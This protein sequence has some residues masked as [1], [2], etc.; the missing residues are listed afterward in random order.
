MN[1]PAPAMESGRAPRVAAFGELLL[2]LT[3]QG[4]QILTQARDLIAAYTG[5]EANAAVSLVRL[6]LR[7]SV[8]SVVPANAVGDA[9]VDYIRQFGV[10]THH[11]V[12]GGERLGLLYVEPGVGQRPTNVIYDREHSG[13]Q[14]ADPRVFDWPAIL[15]GCHWL[16]FSGTAPSRGPNIVQAIREG[17]AEAKRRRIPVSCDVNYRSR[18]WDVECARAVLTKL[19]PGVDYVVCSLADARMLIGGPDDRPLRDIA[20]SVRER[21]HLKAVV[22]AKRSGESSSGGA[23]C[24]ALT[25]REGCW[26]SRTHEL[27]IVDR[28]GGGDALTAGAIYCWLTGADSQRTVEFAVAAAVL[29]HTIP[30]DFNLASLAD[31]EPVLADENAAKVRR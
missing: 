13:F 14:Q 9:C 19:L 27:T 26:L 20:A 25:D 30:G 17:C 22:V 8:V 10:D 21:F 3:T 15:D 1:T 24:A 2:R 28:I 5:A 6:G 16:H 7:A 11:V 29:K 4:H 18:L 12:R 23:L 31:I